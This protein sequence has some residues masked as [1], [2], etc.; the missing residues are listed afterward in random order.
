MQGSSFWDLRSITFLP[1]ILLKTVMPW[2][3]SIDFGERLKILVLKLLSGWNVPPM[4]SLRHF[5]YLKVRV[6]L[7][8]CVM[9]KRPA[10]ILAMMAPGWV[11][12]RIA[13]DALCIEHYCIVMILTFPI[14]HYQRALYASVIWYFWVCQWYPW[15]TM[16]YIHNFRHA[17]CIIY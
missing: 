12:Q 4:H 6:I 13:R 10:E 11:Y 3:L 1:D 15:A 14:P 7:A 2:Y 9:P 16:G 8:S 5:L 17:C